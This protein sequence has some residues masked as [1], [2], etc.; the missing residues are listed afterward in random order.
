MLRKPLESSPPHFVQEGLTL[1]II[2]RV[3]R[4]LISQM[5]LLIIY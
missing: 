5:G 1:S 4:L 2:E 3:D